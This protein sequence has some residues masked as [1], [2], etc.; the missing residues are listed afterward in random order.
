MDEARRLRELL[1]APV[2]A[3]VPPLLPSMTDEQKAVLAAR[4]ALP[5]VAGLD[6][7]EAAVLLNETPEV[8]NPEPQGTVPM[9]FGMVDVES[10]LSPES[11]GRFMMLPLSPLIVGVIEA[12]DGARL[13]A[14]AAGLAAA[15]P[16]VITPAER[17]AIVALASRTRP[18]P[19]WSPTVGGPNFA[20]EHFPGVTFR[21]P[22]QGLFGVA[23]QSCRDMILPEMVAEARG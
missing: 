19:A 21:V 11:I 7:E 9:P 6:D 15:N 14:Y 13:A 1:P 2:Q 17:D 4:L 18:D 23:F 22:V 16:P 12:G 10:L 3:D 8:Q 5:D 20:Q